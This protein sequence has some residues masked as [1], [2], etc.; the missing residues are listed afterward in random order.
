MSKD[1]PRSGLPRGTYGHVIAERRQVVLPAGFG[2]HDLTEQLAE[3]ATLL[4]L[5]LRFFLAAAAAAAAVFLIA[6]PTIAS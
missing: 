6:R 3:E 1:V 4:D 5:R 2:A